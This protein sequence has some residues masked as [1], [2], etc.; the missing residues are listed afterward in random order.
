MILLLVNE[1]AFA[2]AHGTRGEL[3]QR[4]ERLLGSWVHTGIDSV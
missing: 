4:P 3:R 2:V 1:Q